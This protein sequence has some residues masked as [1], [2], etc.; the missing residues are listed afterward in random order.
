MAS[1]LSSWTTPVGLSK[2]EYFTSLPPR[3]SFGSS[4]SILI[5][6]ATLSRNNHRSSTAISSEEIAQHS[7]YTTSLAGIVKLK[8]KMFFY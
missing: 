8:V 7:R 4:Q 1:F 2:G 5:S 3:L 6:V